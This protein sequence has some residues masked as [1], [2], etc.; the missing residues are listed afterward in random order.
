M[1]LIENSKYVSKYKRYILFSSLNFLRD[2]LAKSKDSTTV[3]FII[4][5]DVI[6]MIV[7]IQ[8]RGKLR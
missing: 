7:I 4:Y 1:K 8:K 5:I 3:L 6:Y 2:I